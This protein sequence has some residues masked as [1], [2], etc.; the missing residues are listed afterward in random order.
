MTLL[1]SLE[2]HGYKTFASRTPFEF[3]GMI[4]AIVGPN[5]SGKSN[6]A[7][8]LR[9]VL[10]EQSYSLLRGRKTEDMIFSGSEQRTRAG[11]ASATV[12]L[13]NESGWLPIDFSEVAITRRAYRDGT[14]E[15]L[16]NGQKVRLKEINELLAQSGL[17]ERTY[18]II[19]QGLVD[20]ALSLK[21]EERRRFFEEAAGIGLYRSRR[22]ESLNRLE[23]TRRNLERVLDILTELEPRLVSLERQAKRAMEYE[24]VR[25]DMR[26]LLRDWYGYHWHRTQLELQRSHEVVRVQ[27]EQTGKVRERLTAAEQAAQE[28]RGRLVAL[29]G[30]LSGW[31]AES[32]ELHTTWEKTNR[33]L[34]VLEERRRALQERS[35]SLER[36]LQNL[37]V[38]SGHQQ[39]LLAQME[40]SLETAGKDLTEARTQADAVNKALAERQRE[41]SVH[42]RELQELR[43]ELVAEQTRLVQGKAHQAEVQARLEGLQRSLTS[44]ESGLAGDSSELEQRK[45]QLAAALKAREE[46][47]KARGDIEV[48]HTAGRKA[49]EAAEDGLRKQREDLNRREGEVTRANAQLEVLRQAEQALSGMGEGGKFLIQQ[50]RQGRVK[51]RPFALAN[52]IV[53]AKEHET[54]L[55]AA[56]G[57]Q[58]DLVVLSREDDLGGLLSML[59]SGEKG[60]ALLFRPLVDL[61]ASQPELRGEGVLGRASGLVDTREK[62]VRK[63]IDALLGE[64]WVVDGRDTAL[65]LLASLPSQGRIVTLSG[66]VYGANGLITAGREARQS[67]GAAALTRSRRIE[68]QSAALAGMQTQLEEARSKTSQQA[69][70]FEALR[71]EHRQREALVSQ[72]GQVFSRAVQQLQ[73]AQLRNDQAQQRHE[74]QQK[75]AGQ[76]REQA[77]A[78]R[79]ALQ[80]SKTALSGIDGRIQALEGRIRET[81]RTL[82]SL[83]ME[84]MQRQLV[85]WNTAV[86]VNDR[87]KRETEQRLEGQRTALKNVGEQQGALQTRVQ[88]TSSGLESLATEK[89]ALAVEEGAL[90]TALEALRG[91]IQP[92]ES[93]MGELETEAGSLQD[94]L[95]AAQ[96]ALT[97]AERHLGQ[98]QMEQLRHRENLESLKRKVEEDFGLVAFEYIES[99]GQA[100]LPL[101]GMVEQLPRLQELPGDLEENITRHRAMLR[102]MGLINPEVQSEYKSVK[103]RHE[104]LTTQMADLKKADEDLRQVI[105]ELDEL[106]KREFRRT[107][108]E[109]AREFKTLFTRLFGGG[110]ARLVLTDAESTADMGIDI[111]AKLPGRRDQGLS[112]LSGGERSLTAVALIFSLLKVSPTPF[113][114]MDEVDAMLDEANVGRFRDLLQEL[115]EKTQFVLI[116]HNRNT[117]QAADVIY[118]VTMGRDSAS[119][120]I[121]LR[122]DELSEEMVK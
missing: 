39:E 26:L 94:Q 14:N 67:A 92:A 91:Q 120:V 57:E 51:A 33:S 110:T 111:E 79:N 29:R 62:A 50:A 72:A 37:E 118:G 40:A 66:E 76:L 82:G 75:Q 68:E 114:I 61:D 103:D 85:H 122:L 21:P 43:R 83:P 2:L 112:L 30:E 59:T 15:Y 58:L 41:R 71:Q 9:W 89:E 34:A 88:E 20:A 23:A 13:D 56:L 99:P 93:R 54:A 95:T 24:Q 32:A 12:V 64:T 96:Q 27:E 100:V 35:V 90:N 108:D 10:G 5:G 6:I 107:F 119:Q 45:V 97:V 74:Y 7:D 11:M 8:S 113:C 4:T 46:A 47:E 109:V 17:A 87:A 36:D 78:A 101:E 73:Q 102:R 28:V 106:M 105:S 49:L 48:Q 60:R 121:S 81:S 44:L 18:T 63:A 16:L 3:P 84:E 70:A 38:Q 25:A 65:A 115:A 80:T 53:V 98:A 31:H 77:E 86:A 116:T 1:K 117:V 104:F 42:E 52:Q 55:S 22:E 69:Q 19:G